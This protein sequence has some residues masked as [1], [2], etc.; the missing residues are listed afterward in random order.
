VQ[1][2]GKLQRYGSRYTAG[3]CKQLS[4]WFFFQSIVWWNPYINVRASGL[5]PCN[6]VMGGWKFHPA[7]T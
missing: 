4:Y 1:P 3:G 7:S 5:E 2:V 6:V